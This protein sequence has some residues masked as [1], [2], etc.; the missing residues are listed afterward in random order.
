VL[1]SQAGWANTVKVTSVKPVILPTTELGF[2][3]SM[4]NGLL[5]QQFSPQLSVGDGLGD[6]ASFSFGSGDM[7]GMLANPALFSSPQLVQA[8]SLGTVLPKDAINLG[9]AS[10]NDLR[11]ASFAFEPKLDLNNRV[12]AKAQSPTQI[13][14]KK[15]VLPASWQK[16]LDTQKK[17][18]TLNTFLAEQ[19]LNQKAT[20][21]TFDDRCDQLLSNELGNLSVSQCKK[22]SS[23]KAAGIQNLQ[24]AQA[25]SKKPTP[26][27]TPV[28]PKPTSNSCR[29]LNSTTSTSVKPKPPS[30][31]TPLPAY[32]KPNPNLLQFPTQVDEVKL[33][34][35]QPLSLDQSLE[36]AR[37]NNRELQV[38]LL[39][40]ESSRSSLREQQAAL[41]PTL[42]LSTV[43]TKNQSDDF[44]SGTVINGQAQ[45]NYDLYT[46]GSRQA[47][48]RTAEEQVRSA[49]LTVE[50]QSETI[51]LNV[52][53]QYYDLQQADA[54]ICISE[55]AVENARASLKD[56]KSLEEAGVGTRF[57]VLR[58]EVNLANT[59]QEL[60]NALSQKRIAQRQLVVTLGLPQSL[61]VS[62]LDFVM[63]AGPWNLSLDDSIVL[64]L[65]NRP[66]L[67][68]ILVSRNQSE[69]RRRQALAQLGP[70]VSLIG[71][72]NLEDTF[73][74]NVPVNDTYRLQVQASLNLFDGGASR[75]RAATQKTNIAIAETNFASQREQIR[76]EVER[77]YSQLKANEKNIQTAEI[78]VK[79]AAQALELAR[80]RFRA[81]VGTQ[82]DVINSE[83]DLTRSEGNQVQAI[84]SYNRALASLQRAVTIRGLQRK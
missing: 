42:G 79:Q 17:T 9:F 13:S 7:V 37:R 22:V 74:D 5:D 49:E 43:I 35:E 69:Q 66:E 16:I 34:A 1:T 61:T 56:T 41:F 25:N 3:A 45:I 67:Q 63:P 68:Q 27:V 26:V 20:V 83:N 39:Q 78:A 70:Q 14:V 53:T 44:S 82:T 55:K 10:A 80:L 76:F 33:Q 23:P 75:A 50:Q 38:S 52:A 21:L 36:I 51:R 40:L 65:Q 64:A 73:K 11:R 62:A 19:K 15:K 71:T 30:S 72:Y 8:T 12:E 46:S 84:I 54:N 60:E 57:D 2:L 6:L 58:S 28:A 81:G 47:A 18:N 48:I 59:L 4:R 29:I 31:S 77:F 24:L 32:L